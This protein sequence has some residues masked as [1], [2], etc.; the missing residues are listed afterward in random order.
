M[1]ASRRER[2]DGAERT[3][4]PRKIKRTLTDGTKKVVAASQSWI[5]TICSTLLSSAFQVDHVLP[6]WNG[7]TDA[8]ENLCALCPSCHAIKTQ[9]EN[10]QRNEDQRLKRKEV[11]QAAQREFEKSVRSEEYARR[12]LFHNQKQGSFLCLSCRKSFYAVFPHTTCPAVEA[13]IKKRLC[14]NASSRDDVESKEKNPFA[15]FTL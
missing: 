12:T 4:Q 15:R 5:C 14:V 8:L 3:K 13:N 11:A 6:L 10:I 9:R 7:G 1:P 2:E